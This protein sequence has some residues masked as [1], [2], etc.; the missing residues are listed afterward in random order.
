MSNNIQTGIN[1][2]RLNGPNK[3]ST[4]KAGNEQPT[5]RTPTSGV[6]D[7][8]NVT[9]QATRLKQLEGDL[10]AVPNINEKLVSEV[11]AALADGS[12]EMDMEETAQKLVEMEAN[13]RAS[14]TSEGER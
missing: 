6:K 9:D 4:A 8:V 7:E 5:N 3:P 1:P 14:H 10:K 13:R 2:A 12:L 11:K